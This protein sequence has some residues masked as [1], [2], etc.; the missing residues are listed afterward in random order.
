M[1]YVASAGAEGI[2]PG[3]TSRV[4]GAGYVF[5]RSTWNPYAASS[6]YSLRFGP[7]RNYH[8]HDDHQ[9][10]TYYAYGHPVLVD[11]GHFGYTA[12]A[13]RTYLI[14]PSAHNVLT[15]PGVPFKKHLPTRMVRKG[16][17]PAWQWFEL[18]DTAYNHQTRARSVLVDPTANVLLTFDRATR[19]TSG[20]FQ[21]LWHLPPGTRVKVAGRGVAV[22]TSADGK[23]TTTI[24]QLP[25]R[26]QVL[27]PGSTTVVTGRL[28][29]YQGWVSY[30][31]RGRSAAPT[32]V[33]SRGGTR[34][35]MVTAVIAAPA[36][37]PVSA[38]INTNPDGWYRVVVRTGDQTRILKV[39]PG[40]A[41]SG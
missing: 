6:Y 32:V 39:S 35:A 31:D 18:S 29:P 24:V 36:G 17:T 38:S 7:A 26:R 15:L 9:S 21:Q 13:Y 27:P 23:L 28:Q 33:M 1:A 5:G 25:L 22:G 40:G 14:S 16:G 34:V 30:V 3:A 37:V 8:G 41:L 19:A 12:G 10:V 2:A 11:S 20:S 4:Y